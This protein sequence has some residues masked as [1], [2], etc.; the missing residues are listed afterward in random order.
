MSLSPS[1]SPTA[2]YPRTPSPGPRVSPGKYSAVLSGLVAVS[3]LSLLGQGSEGLSLFRAPAGRVWNTTWQS[4]PGKTYFLQ[5]SSDLVNWEY[6]P[7]VYPG[8]G[9]TLQSG[10]RTDDGTKLFVRQISTD[11]A[12][13]DAETAD[14]DQDG[15]ANLVELQHGSD[16]FNPSSVADPATGV[17]GQNVRLKLLSSQLPNQSLVNGQVLSGAPSG[18]ATVVLAGAATGEVTADGFVWAGG[19][20]GN[21]RGFLSTGTPSA[22]G[23]SVI[24]SFLTTGQ[25]NINGIIGFTQNGSLNGLI[26]NGS[27]SMILQR[28]GDNSYN[29]ILSTAGTGNQWVEMTQT[30]ALNTEYRTMVRKEDDGFSSWIQGGMFAN[31]GAKINSAVW[32]P[33][34]RWKGVNPTISLKA[35]LYNSFAGPT[36]NTEFCDIDNPTI[37]ATSALLDYERNKNGI[38]VPTLVPLPDGRV[39]AAWQNNTLHETNDG[40]IKMAVRNRRGVWGAASIMIPPGSDGASNVGPVLHQLPGEVSLT[41]LSITSG[42]FTLRKRHVDVDAA[43]TITLGEPQTVFE[44]GLALN[45][46]LSLPTGRIVA[47]WHT[48]SSNWKNLVSYSDDGG[49]TWTPAAMPQFANRAGEGFAIIEADGTLASYWRTDRAAVYRSTSNDDGATW[50]ALAPTAIPCANMPSQGLLGSRVCGYKRPSDGKVVIIGN[51]S[52]THREKLTVWLVNNGE[53]EGSQSLLPWDLPDGSA[54]GI[55][56]PDIIV[57]PDDSMTVIAA[58]WLGGGMGSSELHSAINTFKVQADFK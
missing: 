21:Y 9:E 55:H 14:F 2:Q 53:I 37:D 43:G 11:Q 5:Y 48:A 31:M 56:Y 6:A 33:V 27:M 32:F 47:C 22:T 18:N 23:R 34:A 57:E 49:T 40:M 58:R 13:S 29:R 4:T 42:V 46:M 50:T 38:H 35:G 44:N 51:N 25:G 39:L 1:F 15:F 41:Y 12:P 28:N 24:A 30:I 26:G 16:P 10:F 20:S 7:R 52:T 19:S 8:T 45:H 3:T 17:G 36:R 54:E